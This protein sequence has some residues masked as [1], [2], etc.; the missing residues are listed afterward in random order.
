M[1]LSFA[2]LTIPNVNVIALPMVSAAAAVG[3]ITLAELSRRIVRH[4][5]L[6]QSVRLNID[7]SNGSRA[8]ERRRDIELKH[9]QEESRKDRHSSAE[10]IMS[11]P[12]AP[13]MLRR[14]SFRVRLEE[15]MEHMQQ[16]ERMVPVAALLALP[17]IID[18]HVPDLLSRALLAQKTCERRRSDFR[19][20]LV[21]GDGE[22]L[23][24]GQTAQGDAVIERDHVQAAV[25]KFSFYLRDLSRLRKT[26]SHVGDDL[27]DVLP[28]EYVLECRHS[29][30][31][32]LAAL[33]NAPQQVFVDR[34]RTLDHKGEER[35]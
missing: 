16:G 28:A 21:L 17:N 8:G 3:R 35:R 29:S 25:S 2:G 33:S 34:N 6:S 18:D 31:E 15:V 32:L 5:L 30:L 14:S 20:V 11:R 4:G 7:A 27:P 22:Y 10:S 13:G 26:R 12:L 23:L 24:F 9:H 1:T 19:K